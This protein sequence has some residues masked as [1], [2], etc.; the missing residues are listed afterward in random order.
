[1]PITLHGYNI[2]IY[3]YKLYLYIKHTMTKRCSLFQI[4]IFTDFRMIEQNIL[5]IIGIPRPLA[6]TYPPTCN[7]TIDFLKLANFQNQFNI[8]I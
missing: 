7:S 4:F 3:V 8:I 1:M 5:D 2:F 6:I